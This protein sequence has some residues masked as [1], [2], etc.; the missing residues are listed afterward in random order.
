[1]SISEYIQ[2]QISE[3]GFENN[4]IEIDFSGLC[5]EIDVVNAAKE[6]GFK[7]EKSDGQGVWWISR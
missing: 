5:E 4:Q 3:R 7:A 1:M 6:L 2:S